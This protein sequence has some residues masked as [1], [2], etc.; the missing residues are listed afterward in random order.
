M[1]RDTTRRWRV[2]PILAIA[3]LLAAAPVSA[4]AGED[5][6]TAL[7]GLGWPV[8]FGLF[9][10]GVVVVAYRRRQRRG[11]DPPAALAPDTGGGSL[12]EPLVRRAAPE[13]V[14]P[15]RRRTTARRPVR[16]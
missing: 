10:V 8:G 16:P 7:D 2:L 13:W 3:W 15:D 6:S 1:M 14:E 12:D 5:H 11:G 4:H 9:L